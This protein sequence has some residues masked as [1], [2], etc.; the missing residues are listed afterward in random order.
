MTPIQDPVTPEYTYMSF[1]C[2]WEAPLS[3]L[4]RF[5]AKWEPVRRDVYLI[6]ARQDT[7]RES[8]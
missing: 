6:A 7:A 2:R 5:Q 1:K 8:A 3:R 4:K